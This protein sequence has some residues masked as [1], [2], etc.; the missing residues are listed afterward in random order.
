M[1]EC[2]RVLYTVGFW[3]GVC[4]KTN[5]QRKKEVLVFCLNKLLSHKKKRCARAFQF[6]LSERVRPTT[7][8]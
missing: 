8:V 6:T 1:G 4:K 2:G 3:I 7:E 5:Q